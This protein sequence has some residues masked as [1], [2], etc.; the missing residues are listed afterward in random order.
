[1]LHFFSILFHRLKKEAASAER[2]I[3]FNL[4]KLWG[5]LQCSPL[6]FFLSP[7]TILP[8]LSYLDIRATALVFTTDASFTATKF[9]IIIKLI[10]LNC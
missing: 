1:M 9:K 8:F 7:K 2:A 3:V 6:S 4:S 10:P 5:S